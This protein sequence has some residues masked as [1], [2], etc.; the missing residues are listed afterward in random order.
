VRPRP[1]RDPRFL[2]PLLV[3][4][5]L[6]MAVPAAGAIG[7]ATCVGVSATIRGTDQADT[8]VGTPGPDVI[9]GGDGDDV[10]YGLG[11]DDLICAGP[12]TDTVYGGDGND[13]I[14]GGRGDDTLQGG[15]G[16]DLLVDGVGNDRL[17]GGPGDDTLVGGPGDDT[18]V[19]GPG[20]D[21]L[22][23]G[24]GDDTLDGGV[25]ADDLAGGPGADR[26]MRVLIRDT[27]SDA[28]TLDA[29]GDTRWY[30]SLTLEPLGG[31]HL[32]FPN[33]VS[34]Y[35]QRHTHAIEVTYAPGGLVLVE[36]LSPEEYLLGLG[37][38]PYSWHPAALR[39][40]AVA[41]RTYLGNLLANPA[42]GVM[43]EFGFDI[44]GSATC[45]LYLGAGRAQVAEAG[46]RWTA[47]VSATAG[48]I[49]LYDGTP[50]LTVYHST[51]GATTRSNQD[52]W[53]GAAVPYLQAVEVPAQDSPFATWSYDLGLDQLLAILVEAGITFPGEVT[54]ITTV[55]TLPGGGPYRVR[56]Q[57]T[58]GTVEVTATRI[59]SAV[60]TYGPALYPSL[61]PAY[62]PDGERYPQT[63][64][65]P[66][67]T[68]KTRP[69]GVT[70]RV[71]GQG[72]GHQLGMPQYG[73]LAMAL[74]GESTAAILNHFYTG[75]WPRS[76]PG[77]LPEEITVGLAW[78]RAAVTLRAEYYVLRSPDG[79]VARGRLAEFALLE[80]A[81]GWVVLNSP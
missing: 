21:T 44:C 29:I 69:D 11:G 9:L 45:Q 61:L 81:G 57:T 51:A 17:D 67:F 13:R 14:L 76:D 71:Q 1:L 6:A 30:R 35:D 43:A 16:N 60:N 36:R 49:L 80:G 58:A 3:T 20:D 38:M 18:L 65:S 42:W 5:L 73:A 34:G 8:L 37:E 47:A 46:S 62:R 40:Q 54:G 28:G 22:V 74:A 7:A 56:F 41:A 63:V 15:E 4:V 79:V 26:L 64:L 19:G 66:T 10:I 12:G 52:V 27:V 68:V 32:V 2:L 77:F 75:L 53:G 31:T 50:A 39:A 59:Q 72:W 70:V 24:P 55:V 25:G 78:D 23:G 33:S 48:K